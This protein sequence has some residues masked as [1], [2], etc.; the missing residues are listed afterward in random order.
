MSQNNRPRGTSRR[1]AEVLKAS[2]KEYASRKEF[3]FE[4]C[5]T[6]QRLK[7]EADADRALEEFRRIGGE[8]AEIALAESRLASLRG[9]DG[10]AK[11]VLTD[12]SQGASPEAQ[13]KLRLG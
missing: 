2:E 13:R 7:R 6:Y 3:W 4:L 5:L 10:R 9:D 12:A 8:A 1:Q 11:S